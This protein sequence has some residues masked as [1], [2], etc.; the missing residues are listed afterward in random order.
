MGDP[1]LGRIGEL[2]DILGESGRGVTIRPVGE[3]SRMSG[4]G[5]GHRYAF[6][7]WEVGWITAVGGE[8]LA[9]GRTIA[10]AVDAAVDAL[11]RG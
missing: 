9:V 3:G 8:E 1:R 6:T 11:R 7:G 10:E 5:A 2:I 4:L